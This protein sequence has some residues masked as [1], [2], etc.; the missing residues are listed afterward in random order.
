MKIRL[1]TVPDCGACAA[2]R[3]WLRARGLPFEE[4]SVADNFGN[5]RRLRRLTD[6]RQVPVCAVGDRVVVG[7]DPEALEQLVALVAEE[8]SRD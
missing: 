5:L 8:G 6:A 4:L 7:Y 2:V 3:C 1:F